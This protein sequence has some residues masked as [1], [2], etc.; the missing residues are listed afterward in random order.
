VSGATGV[1]LAFPSGKFVL[2][3]VSGVFAASEILRGLKSNATS[4][5][6]GGSVGASPMD[7]GSGLL[8]YVP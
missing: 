1:I 2:G 3:M 5:R 7:L 8:R 6:T 4:T